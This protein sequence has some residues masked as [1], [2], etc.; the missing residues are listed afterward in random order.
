M[1]ST[2]SPTSP[3]VRVGIDIAKLTHQILWELPGGK[4]RSLRVANTKTE[5]DRFVGMLGALGW[6][7]EIAFEATGDY[8]RP[9]AYVLGRAGFRLCLVS[10]I[11]V[12]RTRE[13]LYN[14]WDKNDPKDA[15]V[16]LHL[17]KQGTTQ[18]YLD[19]LV[20]GHQD[21]QEMANTYQQV[22]LRKVRLQH[23]LVTHH[24]PLYF[25]EAER[26]LHSSR[27]EW[28]TE[29]L[30]FAPCPAAVRRYTKTA[31]VAAARAQV[32]G[33]KVDKT[34][35]LADFYETACGSVGLPV[36]D[37]S[38][39]IRMFRVVL[40]E[41]RALC[42][43]RKRL[44]LEIATR[45]ATQPDFV[46]LQTL[47]GI[48]P[49]LAMTILAE[50]RDLRRFSCVRQFL[51]YCGFDLCTA[52]SGQFRGT[53][54]LSKRGNARLRYFWMAGTVAIRMQQNSFRRKLTTSAPIRRTRTGDGRGTRRWRSKWRASRTP[55]SRYRLSPLPG[56]DE[57]KWEDPFATGRRGAC[58]L[59]DNARLEYDAL[60]SLVRAGRSWP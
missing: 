27:A 5:I 54:R 56:S 2:F 60:L 32:T 55:W 10:S 45:L 44:E 21:L 20:T 41:Y 43:L 6:P 11:A 24:L 51:K 34:R 31:F 37:T 22:S 26:Y 15:Q 35:W 47:P 9:L 30:L 49:I 19:P 50:A 38:E 53:T 36:A 29:L 16:I 58:D 40:E 39:T 17:L 14:S 42:Q 13:A 8:H 1:T 59:V 48:G 57:T 18:R 33:R 23:S 4:R 52:Q 12:A 46:R 7:C 28:F 25:P 3:V